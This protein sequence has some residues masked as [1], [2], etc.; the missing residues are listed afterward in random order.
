MKKIIILLVSTI[1]LSGCSSDQI[2]G[3]ILVDSELFAIEIIAIQE[4]QETDKQLNGKYKRRDKY[5]ISG[6]E[7]ETHEY[8]TPNGEIGYI[9]YLTKDEDGKIYKK[10][11]VTGVEQE[12]GHD[13]YLINS[14]VE[15]TATTTE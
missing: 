6:V 7:Y 4:L 9:T 11:I 14:V 13:W 5:I 3:A 15:K 10:A 8:E 12:R 1:I 2:A